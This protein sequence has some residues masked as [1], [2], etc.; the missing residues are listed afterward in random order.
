VL[1]TGKVAE[2]AAAATTGLIEHKYGSNAGKVVRNSTD[3]VTNICRTLRTVASIQKIES[4]TRSMAKSSSKMHVKS[5][6][7]VEMDDALHSIQEKDEEEEEEEYLFEGVNSQIFEDDIPVEVE[8]QTIADSQ[9]YTTIQAEP[10]TSTV[11]HNDVYDCGAE[12]DSIEMSETSIG[13]NN[14]SDI[15]II[16]GG[17]MGTFDT[18]LQMTPSELDALPDQI[19]SADAQS[20][21]FSDIT[22][23]PK[24]ETLLS[25]QISSARSSIFRNVPR[26]EGPCSE[27]DKR[28]QRRPTCTDC[29]S[30]DDDRSLDYTICTVEETY[31]TNSIMSDENEIGFRPQEPFDLEGES[32]VADYSDYE[33]V[34]MAG[35]PT[36]HCTKHDAPTMTEA[37]RIEPTVPNP[38]EI[39]RK[40]QLTN[41]ILVP[42]NGYV[43]SDFERGGKINEAWPRDIVS[44]VKSKLGL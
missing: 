37:Q 4:V 1:S 32:F 36:V 20:D 39:P 18:Q 9:E 27:K 35:Y 11:E 21:F 40:I 15:L 3:T 24:Y 44:S 42:P 26:I 19:T 17:D 30:S 33:G 34:L 13:P 12:D 38:A 28:R 23:D 16:Q 41:C 2:T 7:D 43:S 25:A 31:L 29:D 8:A 10:I 5:L 14:K 6:V 22:I